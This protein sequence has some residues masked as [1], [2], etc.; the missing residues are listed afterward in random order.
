[1][2]KKWRE[3]QLE[4]EMKLGVMNK[5][6]LQGSILKHIGGWVGSWLEIGSTGLT[7]E[8][9]KERNTLWLYYFRETDGKPQTFQMKTLPCF[10]FL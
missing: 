5:K 4:Y 9:I 2:R 1:M 3:W 10:P 7:N 8:H 6:Y